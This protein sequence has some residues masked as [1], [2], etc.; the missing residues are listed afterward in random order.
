MAIPFTMIRKECR[1]PSRLAPNALATA[2]T[3]CGVQ[4]IAPRD[5]A[6]DLNAG[7]RPLARQEFA[8]IG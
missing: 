8:K 5:S 2:T 7:D 4:A 3:G 6:V 1:R